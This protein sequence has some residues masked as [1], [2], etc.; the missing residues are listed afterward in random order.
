MRTTKAS[1]AMRPLAALAGASALAYVLLA[2]TTPAALP[3]T[4]ALRGAARNSNLQPDVNVRV[5]DSCDASSSAVLREL[6][7]SNRFVQ[8]SAESTSILSR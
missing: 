2:L 8:Q 6:D 5:C 7:E 4:P 1:L 3:E